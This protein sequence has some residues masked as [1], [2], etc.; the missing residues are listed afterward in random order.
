[1]ELVSMAIVWFGLDQVKVG[2]GWA[3]HCTFNSTVWWTRDE[4]LV[5]PEGHR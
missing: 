3:S 5:S 4:M 1:M 2:V